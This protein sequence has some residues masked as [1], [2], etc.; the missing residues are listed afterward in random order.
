MNISKNSPRLSRGEH[1]QAK[2]IYCLTTNEYFSC[3]K[4]AAIKY[5]IGPYSISECCR[6]KQNTAGKH[7]I[8][9]DRLKWEFVNANVNK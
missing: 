4:D 3:I 7:P 2:K 1:P 5:K 9:G 8:T 6:G